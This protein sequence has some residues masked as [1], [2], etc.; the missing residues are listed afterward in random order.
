MTPRRDCGDE[1]VGKFDVGT[2]V[3]PPRAVTPRVAFRVGAWARFGSRCAFGFAHRGSRGIGKLFSGGCIDYR[4]A[5]VA[6]RHTLRVVQSTAYPYA[7]GATGPAPVESL[8]R[9]AAAR[10]AARVATT[11]RGSRVDMALAYSMDDSLPCFM[12]IA[13]RWCIVDA[14]W[15]SLARAVALP[16]DSLSPRGLR[17]S[18]ELPSA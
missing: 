16:P 18:R 17:L 9:V 13:R 12:D 6:Y 5:L 14:S 15:P 8:T 11:D 3:T 2:R 4:K 10:P 1:P 7:G